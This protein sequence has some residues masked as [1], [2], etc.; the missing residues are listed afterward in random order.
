MK[1]AVP[2]EA[3]APVP[4]VRAEAPAVPAV[5]AT[6]NATPEPTAAPSPDR[7]I[8]TTQVPAS[9]QVAP[10]QAQP[11]VAKDDVASQIDNA[12][13][14]RE[15]ELRKQAELKEGERRA[16][17]RRERRKRQEIEAA[18]SCIANL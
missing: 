8:A 12:K 18:V 15:G 5:L 10:P 4:A 11:V 13:K 3:V 1:I 6:K 2:T 17:Q 7:V 9:P 14:A 16:V